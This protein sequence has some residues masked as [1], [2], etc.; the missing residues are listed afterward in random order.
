MIDGK[1]GIGYRKT[2][3]TT[4][5]SDVDAVYWTPTAWQYDRIVYNT[6]GG[7]IRTTGIS[8]PSREWAYVTFENG[9]SVRLNNPFNYLT[10]IFNEAGNVPLE[11]TDICFPDNATGWL[12]TSDGQI[13]VTKDSSKSWNSQL[14]VSR[15]GFSKIYFMDDKAGWA[16][17]YTNSFYKTTDGGNT[18]N[19]ISTPGITSKL[20]QFVFTTK[21]RGFFMAGREVYETS[22]GGTSW[23]RSCKMGNETFQSITKQGANV[24]ILSLGSETSTTHAT[25]LRY[26]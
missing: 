17:S 22:D 7:G 3:G 6:T 14:S 18:W 26:Q 19:K 11:T 13:L 15:T 12:C 4:Y 24:Y 23:T 21:N 5:G 20:V 25:I 16:S 8:I 1:T 9:Q 2:Y 10:Y